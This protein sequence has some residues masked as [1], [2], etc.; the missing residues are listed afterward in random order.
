MILNDWLDILLFKKKPADIASTSLGDGLKQLVIANVLFGLL[1]GIVGY[2]SYDQMIASLGEL[3]GLA[4]AFMVQPDIISI[5]MSAI[6]AP[7]FAVI[8]ILILG[9]ILH[10]FSKL[11]GG[12][13]SIGNYIGVLAYIDA[14]LTGTAIA[15]LVVVE[16]VAAL[17]GAYVSVASIT[18]LIS[19]LI[20]LWEIAL[21]VLAAEA[22][23]KLSRTRAII[24]TVAIP[25]GLT[26]LL[27]AVLMIFFVAI[28]ASIAGGGLV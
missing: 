4:S 17:V 25:I 1:S 6:W 19:L 24:A 13:A 10:L 18:A 3:S 14:A 9:T 27:L 21:F 28:F 15:A 12:Q 22:V 16:I 2:L 26:I 5:I 20:V 7:I 11:L 8:I 23:H